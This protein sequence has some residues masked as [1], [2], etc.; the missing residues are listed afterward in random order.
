MPH[1]ASDFNPGHRGRAGDGGATKKPL[2]AQEPWDHRKSGRASWIGHEP[3]SRRSFPPCA[4][5]FKPLLRGPA[6]PLAPRSPHSPAFLP[7]LRRLSP[8]A[9][10][11]AAPLRWPSL[12][13]ASLG[14]SRPRF[15]HGPAADAAGRGLRRGRLSSPLARLRVELARGAL[16]RLRLGRCPRRPRGP[17]PC[18]Q[19]G[20]REDRRG[21]SRRSAALSWPPAAAPP[22]GL[23]VGARAAFVFL[24]SIA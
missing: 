12:R 14:D 11:A 16:A 3:T 15:G 7:P 21:S 19:S 22:C 24:R 6:S 23:R 4:D 17:V 20:P 9:R 2:L 13:F 8:L 1:P 10:G 5:P 18:G